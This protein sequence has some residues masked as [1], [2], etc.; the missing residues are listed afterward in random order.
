MA[1]AAIVLQVSASDLE[2]ALASLQNMPEIVAAAQ[3][4][5]ERI[6]ATIDAPAAELLNCLQKC[7][8]L[9]Q[10]IGLELVYVNYE[11]DMDRDGFIACAS[12]NEILQKMKKGQ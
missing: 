7:Q 10:V 11:D 1:I 6:A 2:G 4:A 8:N 12:L 9:P 5:P 3:G